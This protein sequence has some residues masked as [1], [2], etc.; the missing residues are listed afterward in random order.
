MM[1]EFQTAHSSPRKQ[2]HP[3]SPNQKIDQNNT[4]NFNDTN[5]VHNKLDFTDLDEELEVEID[6]NGH[7]HINKN[8]P[9]SSSQKEESP[10]LP[11]ESTNGIYRYIK[12][13]SLRNPRKIGAF[14]TFVICTLPLI[15]AIAI[16]ASSPMV[17]M[18]LTGQNVIDDI[19][20]QASFSD[21]HVNSTVAAVATDNALCSS[22][23]KQIMLQGG[24]A[25]DAAVAITLCLGVVSPGSSGIGGGCYILTHNG[26]TK[27]NQFID[28]REYAPSGATFDMYVKNSKL[29]VDGGLAIGVFAELKGLYLIWERHCILPWSELVYPAAIVAN[30][31]AIDREVA[32]L[33]QV[34]QHELMSN[35]YPE[36]S[37]LYLKSDGSLKGFGDTVEQPTLS[38]TL[39]KIAAY[40]PSYLYDTMAATIATEIQAAGGIITEG[41][42]RGYAPITHSTL[43]VSVMG[44]TYIGIGGSSSGGAVV[45]GILN[46]MGGYPDPLA[47]QG[48]LYTHRLAEAMKHAFAIRLNLGDPAF[49][50]TTGPIEALLSSEY[51]SALREKTSDYHVLNLEEYGGLYNTKYASTQDH[52]TTS[53]SVLDKWGNA[54]SIT[55]TVNTEFGSKVISPSTGILFNNQ[56]DDFSIPGSPNYFGLAASPLNYPQPYKRP[57]SSMS[58]SF[59]LDKLGD[60]RL[61][62]GAS[63]G[64]RIITA[65]A[66]VYIYIYTY[67]YIYI[68]IYMYKYVYICISTYM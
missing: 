55:S 24:N 31:W 68:Y 63:G 56:M 61:I 39:F 29:A 23:G 27:E 36:L 22:I 53:L 18:I 37:L 20:V 57:L 45:G 32:S 54:V 41:D 13:F 6:F 3:L 40:G 38:K 42:I 26:T 16:V 14:Y 66:Q 44:H 5:G 25:M 9:N 21:F 60:I 11:Y 35:L 48:S 58:P 43:N 8:R 50:N 1:K 10:I 59:V 12:A 4:I 62:G 30:S 46:F 28:S 64:P 7:S 51:M 2:T 17:R 67:I 15:I 52:G 33:L 47:S 65:S 34:V 19:K 49:V